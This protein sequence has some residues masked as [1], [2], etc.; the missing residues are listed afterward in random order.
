VANYESSAAV[1]ALLHVNERVDSV[2]VHAPSEFVSAV[3][4]IAYL[5]GHT[6]TSLPVF[7]MVHASNGPNT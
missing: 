4:D 1:P 7:V 6:V 2:I 5:K 3:A